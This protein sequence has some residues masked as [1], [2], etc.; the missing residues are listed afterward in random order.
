MED[1]PTQEVVFYLPAEFDKEYIRDCYKMA[2]GRLKFALSSIPMAKICH[3]ENWRYYF[4]M[5]I[6]TF[7]DLRACKVMGVTEVRLGAPL[8]F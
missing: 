6:H 3:D 5:P 2:N 8:A 7:E 1:C 4:D